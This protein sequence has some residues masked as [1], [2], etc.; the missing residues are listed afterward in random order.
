MSSFR[1]AI[2]ALILLLLIGKISFP[3]DIERTDEYYRQVRENLELFRDVYREVT[4]K[5][6]DEIEPKEFLRSGIRGMLQT[7][8]PYTVFID[9]SDV[10]D[11]QIMTTGEY[12][13]V[14]IVIS[15]RGE[16]KV[17]TVV[18]AIEGTPAD[19][20]GIRAGDEIIEID[21]VSTK[22]FDTEK[23]ASM[24]RGQPGTIV[25]LKI[26]RPGIPEALSYAIVRE[27]ITVKDVSNYGI[28][29]DSVGYIRLTRFSRKAG[30]EVEGALRDLKS[31]GMR[32][33]ILDLRGNP[34]GLLESA[35]EVSE[36]FLPKGQTIVSTRGVIDESNR[37][38][39]SRV[40]PIC[41]DCNLV[42]LVDG[43]SA[44]ASEIVAGAI[45]DLDR[46]VIVGE[47][48]FGK[49]LVQSLV[50]FKNGAELKI[51]TAKYY[52]PSG[53]LIQKV[54]YFGE[55]NPTILKKTEFAE[56]N[57]LSAKYFTTQGREV[58]GGG[59]ITPDI[60]VSMPE[61]SKLLVAMYKESA[62]FNFANGYLIDATLEDAVKDTLLYE[63]F[64]RYLQSA[65]F[66]YSI[67]GQAELDNLEK[68]G[69]NQ[70][71]GSD[72]EA[73]IANLKKALAH[74]K[75]MDFD[76]NKENIVESVRNEFIA[77]SPNN[78]SKLQALKDGDIQIKKALE[79]IADQ[80]LYN[81]VLAGKIK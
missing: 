11:I 62:F 68:I 40:T 2:F 58:F 60:M 10:D 26:H 52:T 73:S 80:S 81:D 5:Y 22:G 37:I 29:T 21:G 27:K 46:G 79:I 76:K 12:G 43:G 61:M 51:T 14:G 16:D 54:D 19:R 57:A 13:G 23:A 56:V 45:Q 3:A 67:E 17:L 71:L 35:V 77:R 74:L 59:G 36:K 44:S 39:K 1:K 24:M 65:N 31:Q 7:L 63:K 48:T 69:K 64:F 50:N 47:N 49:G 18:S 28:I 38:I 15:I 33:L 34:G 9:E 70:N 42:V 30:E 78:Q 20:L 75:A 66:D 4:A 72:F 55:D 25:N 41:Q 53:R 8:D 32:A 6:V